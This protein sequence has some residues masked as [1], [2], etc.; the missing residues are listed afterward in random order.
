[1]RYKQALW[2]DSDPSYAPGLWYSRHGKPY[3]R[4]SKP[5]VRQG[6]PKDAITLPGQRGDHR[7]LE[8]AAQCRKL[9]RAMVEALDGKSS[10]TPGTWAWVI[11]CWKADPIGRYRQCGPNT[12]KDYDFRSGKWASIIG[13]MSI[14][15]LTYDQIGAIITTMRASGYS[16]SLMS[17]LFVNLR[18]LARYARGPLKCE[19]ARAVTD[20]LDDIKMASPKPRDIAPTP[21]QIRA[22]IDEADARGLFAFA[23]GLLIQW[24]YALRAVDVRGQWLKANPSEGGIIRDGKRWQDGLTW[25]MFTADLMQFEKVISKTRKS[26]PEPIHL[27]VTPE[28]RARLMLLRNG[29]GIGPVI[30]SER[31]G[32]PYT[33][34]GWSQ[35]FR[36][37]RD[38]LKIDPNVKMMD[39]RAGALTDA[40]RHGADPFAVRDAASHR[41]LST[42]GRYVRT[43]EENANKVVKMRSGQ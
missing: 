19:A 8:R 9:T 7:A 35:C 36:R 21:E 39:T 27:T 24:T 14:E 34:Y 4:P 30:T 22:I 11:E 18:S 1:M 16:D 40:V 5:A 3:W 29:G 32:K 17:K 13:H 25:D 41:H 26:I 43:R 37:I 31:N 10:A 6:Y 42:T 28:V 20:I 15:E 33:I 12:Q 38:D 23:T 2:D